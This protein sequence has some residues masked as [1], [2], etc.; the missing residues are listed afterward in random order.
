MKRLKLILPGERGHAE[1]P[2]LNAKLADAD[3][4]EELE[5]LGD[6]EVLFRMD[7]LVRVRAEFV[8]AEI[9]LQ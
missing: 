4:G 7:D 9:E 2:G 6:I 5:C 8:V 1:L 3:T